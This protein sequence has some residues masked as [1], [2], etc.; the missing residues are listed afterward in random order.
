MPLHDMASMYDDFENGIS[1]FFHRHC[2]QRGTAEQPQP[3]GSPRLVLST[4]H[5]WEVPYTY[6][7]VTYTTYF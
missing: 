1:P 5:V 3:L 2:Y 4:H 6:V 7:C